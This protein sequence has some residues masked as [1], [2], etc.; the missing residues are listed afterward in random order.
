MQTAE[1]AEHAETK[2]AEKRL[3]S[4]LLGGLGDLCG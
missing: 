3:L 2:D 4:V 1:N